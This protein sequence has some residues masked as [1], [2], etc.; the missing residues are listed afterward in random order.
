[1]EQMV[2][3]LETRLDRLRALYDQYFMGF[4]RLEPLVPRKEVDRR[5][6]ILRK[7][8]IRNTG[9][10][11]RFNMLIQRYN[12]FQTHW[13]RVCRQIE[14]GTYKHHVLRA[15][16]RFEDSPR[17]VAPRAAFVPSVVPLARSEPPTNR[18]VDFEIDLAISRPDGSID[19]VDPPT[20]PGTLRSP[21]SAPL[22]PSIPMS[23]LVGEAA[24]ISDSLTSSTTTRDVPQTIRGIGP[25]AAAPSQRP[26]PLPASRRPPP[27][28]PSVQSVP[29]PSTTQASRGIT[30][31]PTAPK[32]DPSDHTLQSGITRSVRPVAENDRVESL[33][34][35]Y[36]DQR[37]AAGDNSPAVSL[38][39]MRR[40][41]TETETRLRERHGREVDFRV[42]II[43]GK[44][45]LRP[46]LK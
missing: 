6:Y 11:F 10:R 21:F 12:T 31:P 38:A 20:R 19:E 3:D 16:R 13:A 23:A 42:E 30:R 15:K 1:M 25:T 14:D 36:L 32:S 29:P 28:P 18:E 37:R 17:S 2:E 7:E 26:P 27:L 46:I 34:G 45:V 22:L 41:V 8:Q 43:E 24:L 40:T 44:A 5:I 9:L 4:E 33:Y 39:K 35:N